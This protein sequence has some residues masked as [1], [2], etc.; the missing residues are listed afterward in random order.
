ME[1]LLLQFIEVSKKDRK[2]F[3]RLKNAVVTG[4]QFELACALRD[5]EKDVFPES[6]ETK[7]AKETARKINTLFRMVDLNVNEDTC[8]LIYESIKLHEKKKGKFSLE[9]AVNLK[10]KKD[11]LFVSLN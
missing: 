6:E 5:I 8:W 10:V 7:E 3:N 11:E 4:Q 1:K 2:T 9:D